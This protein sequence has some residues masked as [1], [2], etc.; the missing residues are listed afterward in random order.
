MKF[1]KI[2]N[3]L[4]IVI[5][6]NYNGKLLSDF[7]K[8]FCFSKKAVHLLHQDKAYTLNKEYVRDATLHTGDVLLIRAYEDDDGV[9]GVAVLRMQEVGLT[10]NVVPLTAAFGIDVGRSV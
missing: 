10:R 7:F 6:E 5:D 1:R 8:D 4:R 2:K 3:N 9:N